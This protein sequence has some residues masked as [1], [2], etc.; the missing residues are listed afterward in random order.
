MKSRFFLVPLLPLL[1]L[2]TNVWCLPSGFRDEG[3]SNQND[4]ITGFSFVPKED[5]DH[6]LLICHRSGQVVA[7]LDPDEPDSKTVTVLNIKNKVCTDGERGLSQIQPHPDFLNNRYVY[8]FYTYDKNGGCKF[9]DTDGPVNVVSRFRLTEDLKMEDEEIL[10]QTPPLAAKVHNAGDMVFGNDG[11]LYVSVGDGG[12]ANEKNNAQK[13]YNLQ[14]A[15]LRITDSGGI[16]GDNP[17]RDSNDR[18]CRDDGQ[19]SST[20]RCSEIFAYGLRNPF[21]F[22]MN[23]NEKDFTQLYVNDVG[24]STWEEVS[25]ISSREPGLN[26]GYREREGPCK[27]GSKTECNPDGKYRDPFYWYEHNSDGD[28]AVTGGAFVPNNS[29]WP[30]EYRNKYLFADFIFKAIYLLEEGGDP[31]RD[32]KPPRPAYE[33]TEFKD[34]RSIGEPVQVRSI[35]PTHC[36]VRI[37]TKYDLI[38]TSSFLPC[39]LTF[40]PYK[41]TKALYYR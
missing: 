10:L 26:Y 36:S 17:F 22:V 18:A 4:G 8:I 34:L 6:L 41:G 1:S 15:L 13:L 20:R 3:V 25:E 40:G 29:G 16:P 2:I 21:R 33:R 24:G 31:C 30:Q 14:G 37:R 9:S 28:G 5:G 7:M 39:Q 11:Y 23:P 27:G 19:T 12:L 32:C 35:V 38:V